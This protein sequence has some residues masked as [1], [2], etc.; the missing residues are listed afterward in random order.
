MLRLKDA[1][2]EKTL[3]IIQRMFMQFLHSS[4]AL[5]EI[6][7]SYVYSVFEGQYC[8]FL[9]ETS[10][11]NA[12]S[13][14]QE[15]LCSGKWICHEDCWKISKESMDKCEPVEKE[16][17]GG[18]Y[19]YAVPI[20]YNGQVIGSINA[21][22]TNPPLEKGRIKSVAE[23]FGVADS[24]LLQRA[25]TFKR[26]TNEEMEIA[27]LQLR[28]AAL[29][30]SSLYESRLK[31]IKA[32]KE[33][34]CQKEQMEAIFE[35]LEDNISIFNK[36][37]KY[38]K[39]SS[40][41]KTQF[42]PTDPDVWVVSEKNSF[43]DLEGNPFPKDELCHTRLF[44]GEK[45][46]NLKMK[47]VTDGKEKYIDVSG[48]PIFDENNEFKMGVMFN[49]D[50]TETIKLTHHINQQKDQLEA[51][52]DNMSDGLSIFDDNGEYFMFNSAA[53]E[54]FFPSYNYMAKVGDG[55]YQAE[56]FDIEGNKIPLESYP[57]NRVM[58][59][60]KYTG[61][62][63]VVKFPDKILH[64]SVSGTPIYDTNKKFVMGVLCSRD[65]SGMIEYET[66]I[67]EQKEQLEI[68]I[69]N[70]D[71][72]VFIF[73]ANKNYY[74]VNKAAAE[75]F[76]H[77][78]L[79][80]LGK[81]YKTYKYYDINNNEVKLGDM[82][83]SR[84]FRGE[85]VINQKLTLR[86]CYVTKHISVNGRPIF[87]QHGN[88]QFAVLCGR[89]ITSDVE[90]QRTIGQQNEMLSRQANIVN[91][92]N[93]RLS[94]ALE[95][96]D[97]GIWEWDILTDEQVWSPKVYEIYG[98]DP[99]ETV[100]L[101]KGI[102]SVHPEDRE[103][104]KCSLDEALKAHSESWHKDF[105]IIHP[106]KGIIWLKG[107]GKIIYDITG[108]P[109]RMI[110]INIDITE[111][112][113]Q[114]QKLLQAE[115]EKNES[116][117]NT[118][119]MKDEF[120]SLISHE[121]KTPLTVIN[122][123]IQAMELICKND[124]SD[125]AKSFINKIRQ[126]SFRQL[127][128]V[129]NLLDIT[130]AHAGRIK[131]NKRNLDIVF[132]TK[133]I[134]ESVYLYASN[135]GVKLSF[136]SSVRK[137]VIGID[138]EKYE[139]ILLNLLSNAIKFTPSGKS[140]IV[141]LR[142][143]KSSICL[144]VKDK[145]TGI[146]RDKQELIF[147]KFG[148]V[149]SSLSRQAEGTGIGLSLVKMLVEAFGGSIALKSD[150]G[151]GSTFSVLLPAF[152]VQENNSDI[153]LQEINDKRLIQAT[154]IEFSDIYIDGG[155][156]QNTSGI[157]INQRKVQEL[158]ERESIAKTICSDLN[159]FSD[160]KLTLT[161]ILSNLK[162][163]TGCEAVGIRLHKD[164]D[165]PYY[166]YKGF[167]ECFIKLEN[168]LCEKDME[169]N[170]VLSEDGNYYILQCVCGKV[171]RGNTDS[172]LNFF[173]GKGSYWTN[174]ASDIKS[175]P[176]ID[177]ELG[178]LRGNCIGNGYESTALVPIKSRGDIIG[179]IHLNDTRLNMFTE[180]LI[181]FLEMLGEQIGIAVENSLIQEKLRSKL[182][183]QP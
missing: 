47:M 62:R 87:D 163:L 162:E 134:V 168:N 64:I 149:D 96:V 49:V 69:E 170:K 110:G 119:K 5:Y 82:P 91:L 93:D 80:N 104:F 123:A 136:V 177:E 27:R 120:L 182:S 154:S 127:R 139:R 25:Y 77:N 135:K 19:I 35:T 152:K 158:L 9:N 79:V 112:K 59:G 57:A 109:V 39:K 125:K 92:S 176:N 83:V 36:E 63:M 128:L 155:S 180:D 43:F 14:Q 41:H 29:L 160:L 113:I 179:L 67:K 81:L 143:K 183:Y 156:N 171:I 53:K 76:P 175:R 65:I 114:Q 42:E 48:V 44:R 147:E 116:L 103:D 2:D 121:F 54:M 60:E 130:R 94:L 137:K 75:Y 105:R 129:N 66:K 98:I 10:C 32:E 8:N 138:E 6:D 55:H 141:T 131:I 132:I 167:P 34:K 165:Y 172:S 107:T 106:K 37:G 16:C 33:V 90:F 78:K 97:A 169:G 7:G 150:E 122:S 159:K 126:N 89:D 72:A 21:G 166:V 13:C 153:N 151:K 4:T 11:K 84:V 17:S 15:A 101:E 115:Y 70:M 58:T 124:L 71:D 38:L 56:Y 100:P 164:G 117:E 142:S 28:M 88:I 140:I 3:V 181:E 118:I 108:T 40:L 73:D 51:I 157:S 22:I 74:L 148:Q 52:I 12:G 20:L 23:I 173:T 24:E 86:N 174:H 146:P 50:I 30:I 95:S 144:E 26:L 133:C 161:S 1:I 31:Q 178:E 99:E 45:V 111:Q 46:K 102:R 85:V 145:G 61:M 68:I 18:I